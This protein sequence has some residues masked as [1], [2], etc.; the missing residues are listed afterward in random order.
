MCDI[1]SIFYYVLQFVRRNSN[2]S[3]FLY[4]MARTCNG[5]IF[6]MVPMNQGDIKCD[7]VAINILIRCSACSRFAGCFID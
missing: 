5:A 3:I 6:A 2:R 1:M 4:R 7:R